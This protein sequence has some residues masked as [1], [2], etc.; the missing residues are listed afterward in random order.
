MGGVVGCAALKNKFYGKAVY[1][2]FP[3]EDVL[4]RLSSDKGGVVRCL[5][6]PAHHVSLIRG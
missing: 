4:G 6:V 5:I 1:G 2:F 3:L